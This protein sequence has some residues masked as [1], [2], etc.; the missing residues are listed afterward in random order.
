MH[1]HLPVWASVKL[2]SKSLCTWVHRGRASKNNGPLALCK[3]R[4]C[5]PPENERICAP[6][7]ALCLQERDVPCACE[8][9]PPPLGWWGRQSTR[10]SS[11][12]GGRAWRASGMPPWCAHSR[13]VPLLPRAAPR[14]SSTTCPAR[15]GPLAAAGNNQQGAGTGQKCI[16]RAL[17]ARGDTAGRALG[18]A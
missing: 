4:G 14:C 7:Q 5:G 1:G 3:G 17:E 8:T 12:P 16:T 10:S 6:L 11:T 13:R 2:I 18:T 9:A 15:G